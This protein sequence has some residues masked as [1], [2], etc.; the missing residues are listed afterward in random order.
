MLVT[1]ALAKKILASLAILISHD[2]RGA[3]LRPNDPVQLRF[4]AA[5]NDDIAAAILESPSNDARAERDALL[6]ADFGYHEA[7]LMTSPPGS[8]DAGTAC[9]VGQIH[10]SEMRG[11]L[12]ETWTCQALRTDRVLG[13][14]AMFRVIHHFEEQCGSLEEALGAYATGKCQRG[15]GLVLRRCKE[16]G[17]DCRAWVTPRK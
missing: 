16:A 6:G 1:T 5:V 8:N 17:V 9:G 3:T 10:A 14:R 4:N 11:V 15:V 7:S 13:F 12:P 2:Y